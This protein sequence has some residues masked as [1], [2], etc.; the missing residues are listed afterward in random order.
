MFK[1]DYFTLASMVSSFARIRIL[2]CFPFH[3][4]CHWPPANFVHCA[5]HACSGGGLKGFVAKLLMIFFLRMASIYGS[6]SLYCARDVSARSFWGAFNRFLRIILKLRILV[7]SP[8]S[9]VPYVVKVKN[10]SYI[11]E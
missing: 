7:L 3:C 6:S 9:T 2:T 8:V 5:V 10:H 4:P 1:L 11:G